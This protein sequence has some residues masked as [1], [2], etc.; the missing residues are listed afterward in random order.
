LYHYTKDRYYFRMGLQKK[1]NLERALAACKLEQPPPPPPTTKSATEQAAG[2]A[3]A[4]G[5]QWWRTTK[6]RGCTSC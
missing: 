5:A 1:A 6:V 3:E 4:V 2:V